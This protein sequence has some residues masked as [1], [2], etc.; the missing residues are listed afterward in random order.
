[1][2]KLKV[3]RNKDTADEIPPEI[4]ENIETISFS[5]FNSV[6]SITGVLLW[7][8]FDQLL[9]RK[10]QDFKND[11]E[12]PFREIVDLL[13]VKLQVGGALQ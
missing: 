5:F 9:P 12:K 4:P 8:N 1:M 10:A 7:V 3:I 2:K 6:L 11:F 13:R